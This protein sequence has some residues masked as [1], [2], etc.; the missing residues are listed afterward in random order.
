MPEVGPDQDLPPLTVLV[1]DDNDVNRLYLLHLLR[2]KGHTTV[3]AR[4]GREAM[5]TV[6]T[7][8]LD[9][10]LM[11]VQ[12]PDMDGLSVTRAIRSGACAGVNPNGIP[13]LALTAFAMPGDRERCLASGMDEYVSKPVRGEDLFAAMARAVAKKDR[14]DA[15]GSREAS[16]DAAFDVSGFVA[17]NRREFAIE[18]LTLFLS[19]AEPKR[20]DLARALDRG[21]MALAATL[22]HDL[23][24]MA[25]PLRAERLHQAMKALQEACLAGDLPA[26]RIH[27]NLASRELGQVLSAVRRH[28][29]L[30]DPAG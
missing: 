17:A 18:M 5:D 27:H 8:A 25:G 23:A 21:D 11:D 4:D 1:V 30:A 26:C 28:P 13:I 7:Q 19:L 22:A 6:R 12:L 15:P 10:I 20:G 29:Y 9:C 24:G 14:Q 16:A 2:K 3:A